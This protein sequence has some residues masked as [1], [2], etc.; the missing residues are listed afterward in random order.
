[1]FFLATRGDS[2]ILEGVA[3]SFQPLSIQ[4]QP[5]RIQADTQFLVKYNLGQAHVSLI[6]N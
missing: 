5:T 6:T 2:E 3:R 4:V 1:M